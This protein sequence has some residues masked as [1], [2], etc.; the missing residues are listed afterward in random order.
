ML[1]IPPSVTHYI[2]QHSRYMYPHECCG[3]LLGHESTTARSVVTAISCKNIAATKHVSYCIA[4]EAYMHAE[5]YANAHKLQLLGVFH[6]HPNSAAIPSRT[7][8]ANAFPYFSYLIISVS[9]TS[10]AEMRSWRLN[11]ERLFWEEKIGT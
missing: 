1:L 2:A 9:N 6:S 3:L 11:D 10:I 7:D 4:A 8:T 5:Q